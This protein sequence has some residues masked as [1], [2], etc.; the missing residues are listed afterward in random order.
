ML[1]KP[2]K[3]PKLSLT[4][5]HK[6]LWLVYSIFIRVRDTHLEDDGIRYGNCI[7]CQRRI[8]LTEGDA[9]HFIKATYLMHRY[10]ERNVHLQC[11]YCN[12]F[13]DGNQAEYMRAMEALYTREVVDQMLD[14]KH[15]PRPY[16]A[17]E[18]QELREQYK[19]KTA[20]IEGWGQ[21]YFPSWQKI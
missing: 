21:D 3:Q 17:W 12:R 10:D 19:L 18:L 20:E 2:K 16:K 13:L 1:A 4:T 8:A 9:G 11:R 6:K 14:T 5:Q 7:S 15:E